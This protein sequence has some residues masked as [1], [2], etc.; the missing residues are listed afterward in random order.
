MITQNIVK[1]N[2][3]RQ[4]TIMFADISGFTAMSEKMDPE[5]MT[6]IMN[7][8][9]E[10][11]G[12]VV[13]RYGGTIDKFIGD[14]MMV[15]FGVPAAVEDAPQKAVNTAIEIRNAFNKWNREKNLSIPLDIHI[16]INTGTVLA[17]T[18]GT[19]EKKEYTVMGDAVNLA[20]RLKDVSEKG[21][22]YV[23]PLTYRHTENDFDYKQLEPILLKGKKKPVPLY[24][25]L[26]TKARL[27]RTRS[28]FER[29]IYS[30]MIGRDKELD[31][32]KLHILKAINGE[33]SIVNIVG[34]T[35]I[36]KSRL[37]AELKKGNAIKKVIYLEGR[38]LS[39]G[40]NLNFHP[41]IDI[42]R[43]WA[44]IT[45]ADTTLKSINKL[46][47]AIRS[48]DPKDTGEILPFI[49]T[50]MGISLK[51]KYA[52]RI[53]GIEGEALEKLILKS[54]RQ[55]IVKAT[56]YD[57][58]VLVIDDLHWADLTSIE[59]LESLYRLAENNRILFINVLRPNY[60]DTG[61]RIL[62]TIRERCKEYHSEIYLEPLD[63]NQCEV[64]I[65]NLL[66]IK[67]LP[68]H[69]RNLITKRVEGNPLFIEEVVRSFIDDGIVKNK[70]GKFEVTDKIE[71]VIIPDT[72]QDVLM[73]RI[74]KL[75][76][77]TRSLLKIASVIGRNFFYRILVEV[78]KTTEK[79]D[80]KLEYLKEIQL[81]RQRSSVIELEYLF[82]HALAQ[83]V[84]YESILFKTRKELHLQTA[85]A[86]GSVFSERLHEFYGMLAL[87]YSKGEDLEK[88]EEYLIKAG[89][90][91]LK[92]AA[93]SE[94]IN[95][96]QE[97]LNLYLKKHEGS[98]NP[99]TIANLEKNIANA[100]FNKGFYVEAVE[101]FDK[102]LQLLGEKEP[103]NKI[104]FFLNLI[105]N[106]LIL[107]KNLY[108][109]SKR[110]KRIPDKRENEII[111]IVAKKAYALSQ[112][113]IKKMFLEFI[114]G[115]R[116]F[117]RLDISKIE[118]GISMLILQSGAFSLGGISFKIS[119]KI[120][121]YAKNYINPDDLS[122]VIHYKC[123]EIIYN[124]LSGNWHKELKFDKSLV[125]RNMI[126]GTNQIITHAY[127]FW[128]C[129][130]DIEHGNISNA[131]KLIA[132]LN[133]CGKEYD[134]DLAIGRMYLAKTKLLLKYRM[135]NEVIKEADK[136]IS[137]L[138]K[139]GLQPFGLFASGMKSYI[140]ILMKD[141]KEAES[142][143]SQI[144][145]LISEIE[146]VTPFHISSYLMSQFLLDL[147]MLEESINSNNKS[148]GS[149]LQKKAYRSGKAVVKNSMKVA[150]DKT[151]AFKLMGVYYWLAGEQKKALAW[152]NKSIKIGEQLGARP[153]LA[154][155]Y[156]EVG[157]R[158]L[159]EKSS[160]T[161]LNGI[162]AEEYLGKAETLFIEMNLDWDLEELDKIKFY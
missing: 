26:S 16:G 130:Q 8:C 158:L 82:K 79:I 136:G 115:V 22:I 132:I 21:Q 131:K 106:F 34:E 141:F 140:Q 6:L 39:I 116:R 50:L 76:E 37:I 153:E 12:S 72:I 4:V 42:L 40:K 3:R 125:D 100:F 9:F 104:I 19:E 80:E 69:I 109:P 97:A 147:Y 152:L 120:L 90:E 144:R 15:I 119:G 83:E 48:I 91:A 70:D 31:K 41:I 36:G 86:I 68:V 51:G 10:M 14:C 94:A 110:A 138:R 62:K 27:E 73:S 47:N 160:Y 35:G 20:S 148:R 121:D 11:M 105:I 65:N 43:H 139:I 145:T 99:D 71:M 88:A 54:L 135:F 103:K 25:L 149:Q 154:R 98:G 122:S 146:R 128:F 7:D 133:E 17:G 77:Q 60:E 24:E 23:G 67:S 75:N 38:A 59:F 114:K 2:E 92:A 49:A 87:H 159:E 63:E 124:F 46:E 143:L 89:E 137:L 108:F 134:N 157:K 53:E 1:E 44:K 28:G 111:N 123:I 5:D 107:M 56:E 161:R 155:T 151:E 45:E 13:K 66:K 93:S 64:L 81:I 101:H 29:K 55:L 78:A 118:N 150:G 32:L 129:L 57:P 84:T 52:K 85:N 33:G 113:D 126:I 74:D 30:E 96:F 117:F 162:S 156:M 18:I 61:E 102:V 142:S 58:I 127:T 95:Y 112:L